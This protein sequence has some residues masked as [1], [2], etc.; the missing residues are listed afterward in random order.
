MMGSIFLYNLVCIIKTEIWVLVGVEKLRKVV[1]NG[2]ST[3]IDEY[4][5]SFS[6]DIAAS[7]A[8]WPVLCCDI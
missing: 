5:Y 3:S 6:F 8:L 1:G 7:V 4:H 2:H